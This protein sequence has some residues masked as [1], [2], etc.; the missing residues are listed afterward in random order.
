MMKNQVSAAKDRWLRSVS[1]TVWTAID[2]E[3]AFYL[4]DS[5]DVRPN[6]RFRFQANAGKIKCWAHKRVIVGKYILPSYAILLL[7]H[8]LPYAYL[9]FSYILLANSEK[10]I[11][12]PHGASHS[13]NVSTYIYDP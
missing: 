9:L 8:L 4:A 6:C 7:L 10:R 2:R 11:H 5:S 12:T 13:I 3:E 1:V